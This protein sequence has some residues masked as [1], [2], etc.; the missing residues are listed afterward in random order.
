M[1]KIVS[2]LMSDGR[3]IEGRFVSESKKTAIVK[4]FKWIKT[5]PIKI[6]KEK[7]KMEF[8]GKVI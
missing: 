4:P 6:H 3:R 2:F 5:N 1:T 8:T 7:R